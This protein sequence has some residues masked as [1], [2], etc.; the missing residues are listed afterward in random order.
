MLITIMRTLKKKRRKMI[1]FRKI[2]HLKKGQTKFLLYLILRNLRKNKMMSPMT[3]NLNLQTMNQIQETMEQVV[4]ITTNLKMKKKT[5]HAM[6]HKSKH[7]SNYSRI[8]STFQQENTRDTQHHFSMCY[9]MMNTQKNQTM[10]IHSEI[11]QFVMKKW[12]IFTMTLQ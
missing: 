9:M 1:Q 10:T 8:A 11:S 4:T 12:N 5:L 6:A 7:S 2:H 3:M